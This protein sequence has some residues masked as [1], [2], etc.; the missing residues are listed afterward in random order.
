M[1]RKHG[2]WLHADA[3]Y[4]GFAALTARGRGQLTG[5]EL[6]DSITLDPHKWLYQPYECGCLLV[7]DGG[8][9]RSAFEITPD[10]LRDACIEGAETNF[11]DLGLQLTRASRALKIWVSL[12]LFGLDAFRAAI[13]RS[14]DLAAAA[15]RRVEASDRLELMAPSSLGVVCLRRRFDDVSDPV[16][17]DRRNECLVRDLEREGF[18]LA[19][20]TRLGGRYAIRL[21]VLNHTTAWEHIERTLSFLESA[22]P[23]CV[24]AARQPD[25]GWRPPCCRF[26]EASRASSWRPCSGWRASGT[27]WRGRP[28]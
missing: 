19:S 24:A 16:E 6:A 10:Y 25:V 9:L 2:V 12:Q 3:A 28:S 13:D 5:M 26:S 11:C 20:S 17:V 21:C 14:L 27:R 7:K 18:A 8:V 23:T 1:C 15:C 4:G 22:Q